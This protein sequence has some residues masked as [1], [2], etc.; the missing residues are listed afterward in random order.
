MPRRSRLS[1]EYRCFFNIR[2]S[3]LYSA[4]RPSIEKRTARL[5]STNAFICSKVISSGS[6][7]LI[8]ILPKH[9]SFHLSPGSSCIGTELNAQAHAVLETTRF[10]RLISYWTILVVASACNADVC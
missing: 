4:S 5:L 8:G 7:I 1:S 3:R 10:S 6:C 2:L 9:A